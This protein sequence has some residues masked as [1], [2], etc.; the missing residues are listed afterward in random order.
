MRAHNARARFR[1]S[2]FFRWSFSLCESSRFNL[3][4]CLNFLQIF[5]VQKPRKRS[6]AYEENF[7]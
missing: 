3:V 1:S 7:H 6:F 5:F 2:A 4:F